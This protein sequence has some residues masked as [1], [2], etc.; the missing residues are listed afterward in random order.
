[1]SAKKTTRKPNNPY[2]VDYDDRFFDIWTQHSSYGKITKSKKVKKAT[3]QTANFKGDR[4]RDYKMPTS[5]GKG[6]FT[7]YPFVTKRNLTTGWLS[8]EYDVGKRFSGWTNYTL[9]DVDRAE[10]AVHPYN[11]LAEYTRFML[12]LEDIGLKE[13]ILVRSSYSEGLHIIFPFKKSVKSYGLA[14]RIRQHLQLHGFEV[15][16]GNIE[17]FPNQKSRADALYMGHRLPLQPESGSCVLDPQTFEPI[18]DSTFEFVKTW[19]TLDNVP[20]FV[21]KALDKWELGIEPEEEEVQVDTDIP[22]YRFTRK[23]QTNDMLKNL[24]NYARLKLKLDTVKAIGDWVTDAIVRLKGYDEFSSEDSR[25]KLEK[26]WAY[27]WA[28]SGLAFARKVWLKS[29]GMGYH[30]AKTQAS[31]DKLNGVLDSF[32]TQTFKFKT[33]A[34]KAI[35][36]RSKEL[37]GE[38][39]GFTWLLKYVDVWLPR[40]LEKHTTQTCVRVESLNHTSN[41]DSRKFSIPVNVEKSTPKVSFVGIVG[42]I[43]S[44]VRGAIAHTLDYFD[45]D[46]P[47]FGIEPF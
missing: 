44:K 42:S 22:N 15:K 4:D 6:G 27:Q 45:Q 19:E 30:E 1:M 17:L 20:D 16:S 26:G 21:F 9:I 31:L 12:C 32:G 38:G 34:M 2:K 40:L 8:N 25:M 5:D 13:Y 47:D 14:K 24:T 7:V 10:S 23:G 28:K 33:H 29:C 43:E 35:R 39:I 11:N 3:W 46:S 18:H 36:A 37:F 41:K